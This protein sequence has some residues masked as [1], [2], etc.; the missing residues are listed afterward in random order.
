MPEIHELPESSGELEAMHQ[1]HQTHQHPHV[2]SHAHSQSPH[3]HPMHQMHPM[4]SL[5]YRNT[6]D[7]EEGIGDI[8][9]EI[10]DTMPKTPMAR[11]CNIVY[12]WATQSNPSLLSK[13]FAETTACAIFHFIGSVSP[14][15]WA[16]GI[17]LMVLVYYTA[18][19]SGA[20][21][22]PALSM[23]FM[24]L[25]H[26][27]PLEML[28]YWIAQISG[29]ICGA[30]WLALLVPGLS[31]RGPPALS[32]GCFYPPD[33]RM[34]KALVF[35]WEAFCTFCFIL[36]IFSVVWYTLRKKGYGNT[37]P[38]MVGLSLIANAMAAGSYTGAALNPAR[39]LGSPAVFG[40]DNTYTFYYIA[41]ELLGASLVPV[42]IAPWY[43]ISP[44]AWYISAVPQ[45]AKTYFETVKNKS[46]GMSVL[47]SLIEM[48][49][50][51]E[52]L[53]SQE[54]D[55]S[56]SPKTPGYGL[57]GTPL[58]I[59]GADV[60]TNRS[61][62]MM[63]RSSLTKAKRSSMHDSLELNVPSSPSNFHTPSY[64]PTIVIEINQEMLDQMDQE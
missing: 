2:H 40:C 24:L 38:L 21:L 54:T 45:K 57:P 19:T 44:T 28:V 59:G 50:F 48:Q 29:C 12:N 39:V 61:T 62:I 55:G 35:A 52:K 36:P 20:H 14:T 23:T 47:T 34:T 15:P 22:N 26:T 33:P 13:F 8:E 4:H 9:D 32:D 51:R 30:L 10:I 64:K 7:E 17:V 27:N 37:G 11:I 18:K 1:M 25:G 60:S 31:I 46:R 58:G 5:P 3:F 56:V 6:R 42:I 41:G 49:N 16:N 43:G 63:H 53:P